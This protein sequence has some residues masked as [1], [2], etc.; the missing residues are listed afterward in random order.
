MATRARTWLGAAPGRRLAV[1]RRCLLPALVKPQVHAWA[2]ALFSTAA[3]PSV[4]VTEL[5]LLRY[6]YVATAPA[7]WLWAF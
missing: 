5:T 3:P 6:K 2:P 7:S 1:G 4:P